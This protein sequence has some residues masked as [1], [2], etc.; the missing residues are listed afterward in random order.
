MRYEQFIYGSGFA[1]YNQ[2]ISQYHNRIDTKPLKTNSYFS[3]CPFVRCVHKIIHWRVEYYT[4]A[5]RSSQK[6]AP[7]LLDQDCAYQ[8]LHL[9]GISHPLIRLAFAPRADLN[10]HLVV[11]PLQKPHQPRFRKP[12]ELPINQQRHLRLL[13]PQK[14]R[15]I[16]LLEGA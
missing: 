13:Y 7:K 3:Y 15:N 4:P 9:P 16:L 1:H 6:P 10:N 12:A 14:R 11:Q 5:K 8:P 2:H